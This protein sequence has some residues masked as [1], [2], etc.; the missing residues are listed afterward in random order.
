MM[1][2]LL[3]SVRRKLEEAGIEN[4]G[5]EAE[6]ILQKVTGLD[7]SELALAGHAPTEEQERE[8]V[9]LGDRRAAGEPLQYVT[10]LAGFRHLELL[11]GPGVFIPRPETE[12]VAAFAM[13]RMPHGATAI[14]LGTGSGA[15]ALSLAQERPDATVIATE[16]SSEALE[17]AT[18]NRDRLGLEVRM[19]AGDLFD[20][21][22]TSLMGS[23]DLIVSNP[24][25]VPE[26]FRLGK[27]VI[28][29]E[30]HVALFA[31]DDGLGVIRRISASAR[32]WLKKGGWLILE[33]GEVQRDAVAALLREDGYSDVLVRNDMT[34]RP[35]IVE[36]CWV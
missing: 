6:W 3:D 36:A 23:V 30:P 27:T 32:S 28:D 5:R 34:D 8:A 22:D 33:I 9:A 24:P 12:L 14:D 16:Y 35:R 25:Y 2:A 4:A 21:L 31:P 10:G 20:G 26:G 19:V 11:V 17:W 13:E 1:Q 29:H 7:R 18:K 15:V